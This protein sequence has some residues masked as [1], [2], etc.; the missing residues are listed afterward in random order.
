MFR[1]SSLL[2]VFAFLAT[3]PARADDFVLTPPFPHEGTNGTEVGRQIAQIV[4]AD[5]SNGNRV[6]SAEKAVE[7]LAPA[8]RKA[9]AESECVERWRAGAGATAAITI[10]IFRAVEGE[11]PATSFK[12]GIQ[13]EAGVEYVRGAVIES[14]RP[15]KETVLE[16]LHA[17]F[18]AYRQGPGPRLSITGAPE[19]ASILLDGKVV[20]VLPK[21]LTVSVG[22]HDVRLESEGFAPFQEVVTL[23]SIV[24]T[25]EVNVRLGPAHAVLDERETASPHTFAHSASGTS[26]ANRGAIP[27]VAAAV[28][29]GGVVIV[30]AG[31]LYTASGLHSLTQSGNCSARIAGACAEELDGQQN[32]R[33]RLG[34]GAAALAVGAAA[35]GVGMYLVVRERKHRLSFQAEQRSAGLR[36]E[37]TF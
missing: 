11:G 5:L 28:I 7:R 9:C 19:G 32:G 30:S 13:P 24:D 6:L 4:E 35:L 21:V 23:D 17:A 2:L 1:F 22:S 34:I 37:G 36:L 26:D 33:Q 20:G 29:T 14:S 8:E 25:R 27:W 12:I 3:M 31:G 15:L 18:R 10:R 16:V